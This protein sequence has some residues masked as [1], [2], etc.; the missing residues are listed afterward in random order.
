[1]R[2]IKKWIY[3]A[4]LAATLVAVYLV[5]IEG[6]EH[7]TRAFWLVGVYGTLLVYGGNLLAG[8]L[9]E[10]AVWSYFVRQGY[11]EDAADKETERIWKDSLHGFV[12]RKHPKIRKEQAEYERH[13]KYG[14]KD[15]G[16]G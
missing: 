1:M 12:K 11:T 6:H 4:A 2:R 16:S 14:A 5:V 13:R 9:C 10:R 7:P 3:L 8:W 15:N